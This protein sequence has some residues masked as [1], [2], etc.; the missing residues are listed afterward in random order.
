MIIA[1][2]HGRLSEE[3]AFED[4]MVRPTWDLI[5]SSKI[6]RKVQLVG[7]EIFI[8]AFIGNMTLL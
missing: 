8:F 3:R 6:T 1:R 4:N 7:E 5:T 2:L